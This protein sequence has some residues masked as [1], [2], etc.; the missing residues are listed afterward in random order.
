MAFS[1]FS[2]TPLLQEK[3]MKFCPSTNKNTV[4]SLRSPLLSLDPATSEGYDLARKNVRAF[5]SRTKSTQNYGN[6]FHALQMLP[7]K[8]PFLGSR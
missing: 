5:V 1:L 3:F 8:T 7:V 2:S 4:I 6:I